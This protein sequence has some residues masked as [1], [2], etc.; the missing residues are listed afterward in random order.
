MSLAISPKKP[1]KS[2][3]VSH[4]FINNAS[5]ILKIKSNRNTTIS[6]KKSYAGKPSKVITD[7]NTT[8]AIKMPCQDKRFLIIM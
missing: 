3:A 1:P 6:L 7:K 2:F 5:K 8:L 4:K